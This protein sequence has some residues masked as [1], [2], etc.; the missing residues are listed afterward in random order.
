MKA[1]LISSC[2]AALGFLAS[3]SD[4]ESNAGNGNTSK[5]LLDS[6]KNLAAQAQDALGK[7]K[8]LDVSQLSSMSPEKMQELGKSA[9]GAIAT[10]LDQVKDMASAEKAKGAIDPILEKLGALKGAL[11]GQLPDV[12]KITEAIQGLQTRLGSNLDVMNA[13]QPLLGKLQGLIGG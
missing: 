13:L 12:S 1:L 3:C 2:F 11:A 9:M 10:Q 4:S 7:M 8:D 6:A 5:N